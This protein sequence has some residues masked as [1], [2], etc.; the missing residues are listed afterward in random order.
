MDRS[1]FSITKAY[2]LG[3]TITLPDD[4][5]PR[6]AIVAWLCD[7]ENPWFAKALVNRVWSS[8]FHRGLIEPT[9]DL[10]PANPASHPELLADLTQRFVAAKYDLKWLH[11]EITGSDAYQRSWR[12]NATNANDHRNFSR[13][14]PR[15][16][17]AEVVYDA[18]KQVT[19]SGKELDNVRSNLERRAIG[20]L[21]TR[22]AG[23][24]AQRVFG[25]PERTSLCD[26]ER[27][28]SPSLLQAIF[29]Q[30]DPVVTQRLNESSW[31]REID[32]HFSQG[33]VCT[34]ADAENLGREGWLRAFGRPPSDS[35]AKLAAEHIMQSTTP[36]EG[37]RDLL[38]AL[39]NSK[40]FL[41]NH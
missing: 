11:R 2:L 16:L 24:Y 21:A 30:N 10:N 38:W 33:K 6:S 19:A 26:C 9:D 3:R 34:A 23:T 37:L 31:L 14:I 22:M 7:P 36:A 5:D 29:L 4:G 18:L 32:E 20:H 15:R 41:L 12:P 1:Q 13:A 17:P 25:Q 35:E 39:I 28:N 27:N 8:Y 40:E